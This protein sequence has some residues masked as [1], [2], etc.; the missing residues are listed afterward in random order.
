[1]DIEH[2]Y[3]QDIIMVK[4]HTPKQRVS[5]SPM[6]THHA[7]VYM[8]KAAMRIIQVSRILS[9]R[10]LKPLVCSQLLFR[11]RNSRCPFHC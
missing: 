6:F 10:I 3:M 2:S 7:K 1:M 4:A 9:T 5:Q 11:Q 8:R